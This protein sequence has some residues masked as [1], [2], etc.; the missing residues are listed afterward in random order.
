MIHAP[1]DPP[2]SAPSPTRTRALS[3]PLRWMLQVCGACAVALGVLGIFLP[4]LPTVPFLLL[5]LACFARSSERAHAWLV[6][7]ARLGP[8]VRPYLAGEGL[9]PAA[10]AKAIALLWA[11]IG[12]SVLL[13]VEPAW[14]ELL[15]LT[16][17]GGVTLYL[18]RLPTAD[19]G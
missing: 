8:L 4:V 10:K 5:A 13:W 9:R 12:F 17:A 11:S 19:P 7:H 3:P 14:L 15:L 2:P 18:L 16:V 1:L 6:E